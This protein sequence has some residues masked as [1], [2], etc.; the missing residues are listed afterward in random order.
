M[1]P[2]IIHTDVAIPIGEGDRELCRIS[3]LFERLVFDPWLSG[4]LFLGP[5][6][7]QEHGAAQHGP[8]YF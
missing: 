8:R 7:E 5:A 2:G 4:K 1:R 6:T 3:E